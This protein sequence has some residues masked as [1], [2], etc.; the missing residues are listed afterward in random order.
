M[1]SA[2]TALTPKQRRFVDEYLVDLNGTAAATR[3]GFSER[4]AKAKASQLLAMPHI[5]EAIASAQQ[6]RASRTK[7]DADWVLSRLAEEANADLADLYDDEGAL[8]P[9]QDWPDIWRKGLVAGI[10][11]EEVKE[12]GVVVAIVRK[13]KLSDRI[14][15]IELI[16]KH[17]SVQAFREQVEHKGTIT[18]NISPEDAEL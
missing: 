15:R 13:V 18:L 17:V 9:I 3:A 14:K 10:D 6:D 4:S 1:Q 12:E 2:S 5:A 8:R 11:V 16:G 7:I